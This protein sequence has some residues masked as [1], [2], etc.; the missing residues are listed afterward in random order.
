MREHVL[1]IV[2]QR[3]QALLLDQQHRRRGD[4][5]I[6]VVQQLRD[7]VF[8]VAHARAVDH[9][10]LA[11]A[12]LAPASLRPAA[13]RACATSPSSRLSRYSM[14]RDRSRASRSASACRTA[15]TSSGR[16]DQ[17][18]QRSASD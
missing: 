6:L 11:D 17:A 10:A 16:V 9:V 13:S 3:P 15:A 2:G 4:R 8:D 5:L 7:G 14:A 18:E 1:E 12:L